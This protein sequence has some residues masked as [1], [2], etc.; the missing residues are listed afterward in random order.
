MSKVEGSFLFLINPGKQPVTILRMNKENAQP[1]ENIDQ[2][3]K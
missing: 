2:A 1:V 3:R